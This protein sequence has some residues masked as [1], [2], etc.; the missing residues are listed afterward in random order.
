MAKIEGNC[1]DIIDKAAWAAAAT[2]G[3]DGP[4]LSATRQ[5]LW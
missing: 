5:F 2:T 4:H 3:A 1:K